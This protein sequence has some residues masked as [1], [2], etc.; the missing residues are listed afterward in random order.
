MKKIVGIF[1]M[2]LFP[3]IA[4][5]GT[6]TPPAMHMAYTAVQHGKAVASGK[7][8]VAC[9]IHPEHFVVTLTKAGK[10]VEILNGVALPGVPLSL[11]KMTQTS[12]V[13]VRILQQ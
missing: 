10:V 13:G 7:E 3:V 6:T 9:A 5:A 8:S 4:M 2:G 11:D 12:Y 1:V